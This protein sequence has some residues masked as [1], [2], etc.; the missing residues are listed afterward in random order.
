M[1]Y[2]VGDKLYCR[3]N[4]KSY[5]FHNS[6]SNAYIFC[7]QDD[8][9]RIVKVTKDSIQIENHKGKNIYNGI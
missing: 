4:L 9:V 6:N 3:E 7:F 8:F 1:K 2:S 5:S